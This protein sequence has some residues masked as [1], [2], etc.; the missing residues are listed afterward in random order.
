M[1]I[2]K[3]SKIAQDYYEKTRGKTLYSGYEKNV[4]TDGERCLFVK[5]DYEP[6]AGEVPVTKKMF[7]QMAK[8][9]CS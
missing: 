3:L 6:A 7:L 4:L 1:N 5:S 8:G 9:A 2:L